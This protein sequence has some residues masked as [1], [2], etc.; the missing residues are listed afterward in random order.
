MQN[1][2][3]L[4]TPHDL[5]YTLDIQLTTLDN[6]IQ[7]STIPYTYIQVP[8]TGVKEL[9][10]DT[11]AIAAWLKNTPDIN[12][13]TKSA[14]LNTL[15]EQ[16]KTASP[17]AIQ[18]IKTLDNQFTPKRKTKG[19]NLAK[20]K[21][22]KLGFVYYARYIVNGKLVPSRWCT[23]T[24]NKEIATKWAIENKERL[25]TEYSQRNTDK[26]K[27]YSDLYSILKNFYAKNSPYLQIEADNG[28]FISDDA[29]VSYYNVINNRFIPFLHKERIKALE[30]IDTQL[31]IQFRKELRNG[32]IGKKPCKPQTINHYTSFIRT[33]FDHLI[34]EGHAKNNPCKDL[35]ALK[36]GKEH[37][38][39]V[40]CY[41]I[42]KLKGVFN[43]RW[44]DERSYLL[45]L[46][47]YSTGMRNSEIA[48]IRLKDIL[49]INNLR[50]IDI[51]E[52]KS[53][54]GTRIVPL[55]DFVYRKIITYAKKHNK[56]P[57][58]Y[59]FKSPKTKRLD[60]HICMKAYYDLA[61][62]IGYTKEQLKA[63]HITFYSGR[64]YWKTLMNA[65]KLGDIEEVFMGHKV[66][67]NVAERYNH[68]DKRG[69]TMKVKE[70]RKV[71][72][73]LD[74]VLFIK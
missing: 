2:I 44:N 5:A 14:Q 1:S 26:R 33:V 17:K 21:N 11:Q 63:E 51:Q 37:Q 62:R 12:S 6:L 39:I 41:E 31:L 8:S 49:T 18:Q 7:D 19:F 56:K 3:T 30:Q 35:K 68:R 60:G 32:T 65:Y 28:R 40:G 71:F 66:S 52:S 73:I 57:D 36:V 59:I 13:Q 25:L 23:H 9:R 67:T 74:K 47:I 50:F 24:N 45:N 10:F 70:T 22:K 64:H 16:Y 54:N 34:A 69:R 58:E 29:R 55:H 27:P 46:I 42:N 61:E 72:A 53:E 20:V 4:L 38:K 15:R 48:R 43:K